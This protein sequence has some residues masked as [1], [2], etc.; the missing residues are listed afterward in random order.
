MLGTRRYRVNLHQAAR[1]GTVNRI[2]INSVTNQQLNARNQLGE[3]ALHLAV[4]FHK[5]ECV[6]ALLAK[7][8][9]PGIPNHLMQLPIHLACGSG[10]TRAFNV[11]KEYSSCLVQ[12]D[13]NGNYCI[14]LAASV[15]ESAGTIKFLANNINI[16]VEN[17]KGETCL[18]VAAKAG[19]L[20]NLKTIV[21]LDANLLLTDVK[22]RTALHAAA[23]KGHTRIVEYL[24][25]L[26][27]DGLGDMQS[28]NGMTALMMAIILCQSTI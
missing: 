21:S 9:D 10:Q 5:V 26:R 19:H 8:A 25:G 14:H 16:N 4:K 6:K 28:M 13:K 3:V 18:I 24:L 7:G 22:G 27:K 20:K 15:E 12:R 1:L 23:R 17:Y 2:R 11:L